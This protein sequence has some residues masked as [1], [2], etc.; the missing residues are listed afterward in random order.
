MPQMFREHEE[1][2]L[3]YA[4]VVQMAPPWTRATAT[5]TATATVTARGGNSGGG[6]SSRAGSDAWG[7]G[8]EDVG[9]ASSSPAAAWPFPV[10]NRA[11]G[12]AGEA[13]ALVAQLWQL[14]SSTGE[15]NGFVECSRAQFE[16]LLREAPGVKVGV[17][18]CARARARARA[19][20]CRA[21]GGRDDEVK[22]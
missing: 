7:H 18:A 17:R 15:R 11:P 13:D 4:E 5:A 3:L 22:P 10:A 12:S 2:G 19:Q 21:T 6:L 1:Q 8:G 20:G 14:Y 9:A 16:G